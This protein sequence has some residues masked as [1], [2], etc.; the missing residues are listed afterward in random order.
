LQDGAIYY[1]SPDDPLLGAREFREA[2]DR[3]ERKKYQ[4]N[5]IL[6]RN[7]DIMKGVTAEKWHL[8]QEV[9]RMQE[10]LDAAKSAKEKRTQPK[11]L[12][13]KSKSSNLS[14]SCISKDYMD[15]VQNRSE[16]LSHTSSEQNLNES[17]SSG[18]TP[19]T[20]VDDM[21]ING[22]PSKAI[23]SE[24]IDGE[25]SPKKRKGQYKRFFRELADNEQMLDVE[26]ELAKDVAAGFEDIMMEIE[27]LRNLKDDLFKALGEAGCNGFAV[28]AASRSSSGS[29][30]V[31]SAS[32]V[33]DYEPT[34]MEDTREDASNLANYEAP[35]ME[36][37]Q[38]NRFYEDDLYE[39]DGGVSLAW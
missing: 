9:D 21:P 38:E 24:Q 39:S 29:Y 23:L 26:T 33:A 37:P 1:L 36:D 11:T 19:R 13:R 30:V 32:N 27:M 34:Y 12:K 10:M 7:T 8:D 2:V 28:A 6:N 15:Q 18:T 5:W 16:S 35:Y 3:V 20:Q 31:D 4:K 25:S 17:T 14:S 22:D